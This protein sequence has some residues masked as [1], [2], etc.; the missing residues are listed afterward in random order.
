M[1]LYRSSCQ[2][3]GYMI[4]VL[5]ISRHHL[6]DSF[7]LSAAHRS[8]PPGNPYR[9]NL[10]ERICPTTVCRMV[11]DQTTSRDI[12][13]YN[14]QG[15]EFDMQDTP[16][17]ENNEIAINYA[18][19]EIEEEEVDD[20]ALKNNKKK[21]ECSAS[22]MLPFSADVAFTAFSDLTRQPSWCKYLH[23]VEYIG[24]V[25]EDDDGTNDGDLLSQEVPLR[26][27][28]WTVGVKGL[29]FSWTA[30]DTRIIRNKQIDWASTSGMY[31]IG[32]VVFTPSSST[33]QSDSTTHMELCFIFV[34]PRVVSSLYRRLNIRKYT[35]DVMLADMLQR[36]RDVVIE[37]DL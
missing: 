16:P 13:V 23:S 26:S 21:I 1:V 15:M 34:L 37:E 9:N 3:V 28:K 35:E 31:N 32:S 29:R 20:K 33:S 17:N 5:I 25:N 2:Y 36:F 8:L 11:N 10:M 12:E 18:S 6:V 19:D 22:I 14:D 7:D 4:A 24:L 27:S 30:S